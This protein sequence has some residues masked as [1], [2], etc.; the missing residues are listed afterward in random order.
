[1]ENPN[2]DKFSPSAVW[3]F[4]ENEIYSCQYKSRANLCGWFKLTTDVS[5]SSSSF[6]V[7]PRK[8][9]SANK[10]IA[11]PRANIGRRCQSIMSH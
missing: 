9:S 4:D 7:V 10:L 2:F 1:M 3:G 11:N 5:C 6:N 8:D